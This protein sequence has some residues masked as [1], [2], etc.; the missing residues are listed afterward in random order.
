MDCIYVA[1]L[2][3]AFYNIASSIHTHNVHTPTPVSKMQGS[4]LVG[5]AVGGVDKPLAQGH[6]ATLCE[7]VPRGSNRQPSSRPDIRCTS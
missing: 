7:A 1:L 5:G 4:Q 3:K 2:S 6:F